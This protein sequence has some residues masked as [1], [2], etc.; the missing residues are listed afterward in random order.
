MSDLDAAVCRVLVRVEFTPSLS[1]NKVERSID[2]INW[3]KL[4]EYRDIPVLVYLPTVTMQN[5][6]LSIQ[7]ELSRTV[8]TVLNTPLLLSG[9]ALAATQEAFLKQL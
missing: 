2:G 5:I 1:C 6:C 9:Y 7:P 4:L 8:S 3:F